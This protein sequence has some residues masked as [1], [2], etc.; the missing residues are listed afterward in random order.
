MSESGKRMGVSWSGE[1]RRMRRKRK[2]SARW[3]GGGLGHGMGV[4]VVAGMEVMVVG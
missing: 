1:R 3:D 2:P 4:G